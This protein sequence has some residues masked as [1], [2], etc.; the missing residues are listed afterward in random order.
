[1]PHSVS[2]RTRSVHTSWAGVSAQMGRTGAAKTWVPCSAQHKREDK[3]KPQAD[4]LRDSGHTA[5]LVTLHGL[6][7]LGAD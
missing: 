1:M 7:W 4:I 3:A 6:L 5:T 2:I